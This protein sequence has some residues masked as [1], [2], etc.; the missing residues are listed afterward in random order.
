LE[1]KKRKKERIWTTL[2]FFEIEQFSCF[3]DYSPRSIPALIVKN[4]YMDLRGI[5]NRTTEDGER[6]RGRGEKAKGEKS[7]QE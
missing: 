3:C 6:E 2:Y 1:K 7:S 5:V 4:N